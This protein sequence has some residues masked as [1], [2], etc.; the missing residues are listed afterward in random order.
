MNEPERFNP[1]A[2]RLT[3]NYLSV[4]DR[5]QSAA[6]RSARPTSAIQMVGVTKYVG[7]N[8]ARMLV[9]IGCS[10]LAESKPQMLW[11]KASALSDLPIDWHLIGHLQRNKAKRTI[12]LI[13][14]MHSLDSARVFEEIQK[15]TF[16]CDIP[17]KL[18]LEINVSGDPE[19][20]GMLVSDAESLLQTWKETSVQCPALT[21]AGLMGMGSVA[22]GKDRARGDFER[23]RNLRD[24]WQSRYEM[25]LDELSMG[26]SDDFEEAIEE[27]STMVRI[28][29]ILFQ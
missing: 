29:S 2:E 4:M 21:I 26:M 28:G 7:A 25:P 16:N 10:R 1:T 11:E 15:V 18:L 8:I 23:L 5:I 6:S 24:M 13:S 17:L 20:S 3:A 9:E 14:T 19:K 22:R 27:G 12:P